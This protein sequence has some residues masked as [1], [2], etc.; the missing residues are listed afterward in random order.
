MKQEL[1]EIVGYLP[2]GVKVAGHGK[3]IST[4]KHD[5]NA[6]DLAGISLKGVMEDW[7]VKLI[8]RPLSDLTKEIAVNGETFVPVERLFN[9]YEKDYTYLKYEL[10]KNGVIEMWLEGCETGS[11]MD[12]ALVLGDYLKLYEW[13]FDIHNLI[14]QGKAISLHDI[15]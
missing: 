7:H 8:L 3:C 10:S 1:K 14:E 5:T 6:N 4:L 13:H 15:E 2:Y 9:T 12:E 11:I